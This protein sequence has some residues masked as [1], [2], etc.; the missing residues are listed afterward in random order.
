[1]PTRTANA[2]WNGTLKD[3]G[4]QLKLGSGVYE[5]SYSFTSRFE[6]GTGTNPEELIAAAHAGCFSMA[7]S[8]SLAEAGHPV[9]Q[10][11]TEARVHLVKSSEGFSIPDI[12]LETVGRVP[13]I[14]E[15]TFQEFAEK[16]KASCP[17]SQLLSGAKITLSAKL[18]G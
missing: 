2:I 6:D 10:V 15:Q 13:G 8:H 16:A 5:T 11:Q 9:E 17:V 7:L 14:D 18:A 3:G 1:M 4:G 12:D